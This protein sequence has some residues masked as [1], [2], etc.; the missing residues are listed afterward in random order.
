MPLCADDEYKRCILVPNLL[1]LQSPALETYVPLCA[2][3]KYIVDK[4]APLK[5]PRR[6][7]RYLKAS[8]TSS[9]RPQGRIH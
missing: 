9:V 7:C 2:D 4:F 1:P 8:C 3:D 5:K 6:P